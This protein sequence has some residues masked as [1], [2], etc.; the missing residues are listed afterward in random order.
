M[1]LFPIPFPCPKDSSVI[2]VVPAGPT[3]GGVVLIMAPCPM[4]VTDDPIIPCPM[5]VG[6]G[7]IVA[8]CPI[9]LSV[10]SPC[11]V[12][13][14]AARV[15]PAG[16]MVATVDPIMLLCPIDFSVV[17]IELSTNDCSDGAAMFPKRVDL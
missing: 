7:F 2:P 11:P 5:V 6:V 10:I 13:L 17:T 9:D 15:M 1:E 14:S 4:A 8:P 3:V 16:P 12:D